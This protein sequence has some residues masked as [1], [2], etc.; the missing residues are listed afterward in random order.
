MPMP[1]DVRPERSGWRD[2][3]LSERHRQ[4][5]WDCPALDLDFLLCEYDRCL[6]SALVEYKHEA[7]PKQYR[8]MPTYRVLRDLGTRATLP[9]IACR[10]ASDFSWWRPVPL[11]ELAESYLP[12]LGA[13]LPELE[14]VRLLHRMRGHEMPADLFDDMGVQI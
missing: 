8:S 12:D 11:N 9:A 14:W 13:K 7:A 6:A 4:W 3:G 1:Y 2:Q 5:G 10:Y